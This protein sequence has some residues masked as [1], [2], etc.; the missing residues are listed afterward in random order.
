ME[1]ERTMNRKPLVV[2]SLGA[3]VQSS[4]LALMAAEGEVPTPDCAIFADTGAEPAAV[5]AWL[6]KLEGLLPFPVHRVMEKDGLLENI[7]ESVKGGRFAGAPFYTENADFNKTDREGQLRRQCTREF[8]IQPI[9]RKIR[10]LLGAK[11]REQLARQGHLVTQYIGISLDEVIRM[12]PSREKW[13][14]HEWPLVDKRMTRWD[15]IRW[16]KARGH[17]VPPKSACTFCPYH[18]NAEWRHLR[19][20][21]SAGW[22]QAVEIDNLI[23]G[24]VRGTKF[25]LYLHKSMKPLETCDLSTEEDKGQ[26][27][28]FG[29]ECEGICGV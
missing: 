19:D 25:A 9:T 2:L 26:Q 16:L 8:K 4:T 23:R 10:E 27:S 12:K 3:G 7:T 29:N 6:L 21:D 11:P 13:I 22:R 18:S 5:Y 28:L 24:G 14:R 17:D 20:T 15:C 1:T